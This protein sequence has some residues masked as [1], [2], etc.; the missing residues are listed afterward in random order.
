MEPMTM[1]TLAQSPAPAAPV[2]STKRKVRNFL[3]DARFQLKFAGYVVAL[4]LVIAGLLGAFL[5]QTTSVLF[6]ETQ[7]SVDSREAAAATSKEL[8]TA[9]LQNKMVEH[10]SD[11]DFGKQL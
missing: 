10:M 5:W 7:R 1:S 11:P 6:A 4:T 9:V 3:L 8:G 2:V